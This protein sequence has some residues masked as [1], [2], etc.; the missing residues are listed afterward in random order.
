MTK[1]TKLSKQNFQNLGIQ[2]VS[3]RK[4]K[5]IWTKQEA[6]RKKKNKRKEG[7]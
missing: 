3:E 6:I 4:P 1:L 7:R 5:K 2:I